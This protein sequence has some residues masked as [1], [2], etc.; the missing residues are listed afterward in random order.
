MFP[1]HELPQYGEVQEVDL[2]FWQGSVNWKMNV[3]ATPLDELLPSGQP[4]IEDPHRWYCG[5]CD[6]N[7][8]GTGTWDCAGCAGPDG[9]FDGFIDLFSALYWT[10][11]IVKSDF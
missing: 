5:G 7:C 8:L 10:P 3:P 9:C 4:A 2:S 6:A 1:P 11:P